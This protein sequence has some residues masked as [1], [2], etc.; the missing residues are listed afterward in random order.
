ML[1]DVAFAQNEV[2]REYY[3]L[4][5]YHIKSPDQKKLLD[6]YLESAFIPA[7]HRAGIKKVGAFYP[8][9]VERIP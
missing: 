9:Q 5:I 1:S 2:A 6:N 3:Q 8:A 7:L 4:K